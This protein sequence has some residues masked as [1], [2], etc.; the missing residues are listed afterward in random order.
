MQ[1]RFSGLDVCGLTRAQLA[2][3]I[4][5]RLFAGTRGVLLKSLKKNRV[6][7]ELLANLT[8][9]Q[10]NCLQEVGYRL[11]T[12]TVDTHADSVALIDLELQPCTAAGDDLRVED[13]LVGTAIRGTFKV[14]TG[15][16]NQ[17]RD[18]DTLGAVDDE[19]ATGGHEREIAHEHGLGLNFTRVVV[20]EL[21][22]HIHGCR[23]GV[24]L[25]F[26]FFNRVL[27]SLQAVITERQRHGA[28]HVF[29]RRDLLEN[30]FK[31]GN[32]RNIHASSSL[33]G[34]HAC[35]PCIVSQ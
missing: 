4:G 28:C 10:A 15:R 27:R 31:A 1:E 6:R 9:R 19:G 30:F 2:V 24:I 12:L 20:H 32:I 33:C 14:D 34:I 35:F 16:T 17:L 29:N 7:G 22:G 23:V 5:Q 11:L 13:F 18:N 8:F 25:S 21:G 26:C 3:D